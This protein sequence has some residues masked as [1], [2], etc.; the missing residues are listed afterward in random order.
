MRKIKLESIPFPISEI[1]LGCAHLGWREDDET[2][3]RL[4]DIYYD[5]GGRFL[6]TAHEYGQGK[7]E[8][9]IGRWMHSRNIPRDEMI[10][11]SKCGED[12]SSPRYFA[13]SYDELLE[14]INETLMRT[15]FDYVDFY[16]L[17]IDDL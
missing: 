7:S 16:L 4:L 3:S 10:I 6:N 11:T 14:D 1:C 15:G 9:F 17:H 12:C 2:S 5:R 13:C 8:A